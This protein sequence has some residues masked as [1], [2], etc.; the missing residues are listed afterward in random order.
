MKELVDG[1]FIDKLYAKPYNYMSLWLNQM[2]KRKFNT[3]DRKKELGE[4]GYKL[5]DRYWH[6][7]TGHTAFKLEAAEAAMEVSKHIQDMVANKEEVEPSYYLMKNYFN[8]FGMQ[9]DRSRIFNMAVEI[10]DEWMTANAI[11]TL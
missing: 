4:V 6:D 1:Q 2:G 8:T 9:T 10:L 7:L 3:D 5:T 11:E